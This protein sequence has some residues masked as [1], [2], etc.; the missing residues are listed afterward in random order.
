ML[1][2]RLLTCALILAGCSPVAHSSV[3]TDDGAVVPLQVDSDHDGLCD[4]TEARLGTNPDSADTDGDGFPDGVEF[5]TGF[6]AKNG[7]LPSASDYV[8]LQAT[9][10]AT[11]SD[12]VLLHV[13][14][15]GDD[16]IGAVDVSEAADAEGWT[17][18]TFLQ[19]FKA[20]Q[21]Y[22]PDSVSNV[23]GSAARFAGVNGSATLFFQAVFD[24]ATEN[25]SA[26]NRFYSYGLIVKGTNGSRLAN[27]HRA[28]AIVPPMKSVRTLTDWCPAPSTCE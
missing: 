8:V 14:G 2:K 23:I 12:D 17:A 25:V 19:S 7:A 15:N 5:A 21:A 24:V 20:V 28:L 10:G 3:I 9:S 11:A 22:P 18:A 13:Y 6:S 4:S 16:V 1:V 27:S 26:C